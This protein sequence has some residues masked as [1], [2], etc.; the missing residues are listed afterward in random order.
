LLQLVLVTSKSLTGRFK[1]WANIWPYCISFRNCIVTYYY[2]LCLRP[3][4]Y[5]HSQ[6]YSFFFSSLF[7]S[8][9]RA[10]VVSWSVS[11][12]SVVR[13]TI[14]SRASRNW[15]STVYNLVKFCFN[16]P[17]SPLISACDAQACVSYLVFDSHVDDYKHSLWSCS[18]LIFFYSSAYWMILSAKVCKLF[19]W[20]LALSSNFNSRW[21]PWNFFVKQD[22]LFW[23]FLTSLK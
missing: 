14:S 12:N 10:L 15:C 23:K 3:T 17:R 6:V 2:T 22:I 21:P 13:L 5:S 1:L 7:F 8:L 11:L 19:F 4:I 16:S 9:H 18:I 20:F